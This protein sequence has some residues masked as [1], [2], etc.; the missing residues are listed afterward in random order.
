MASVSR[1]TQTVEVV[2]TKEVPSFTISDL[3]AD[4][5]QVIRNA[6]WSYAEASLWLGMKMA[7]GRTQ[8]EVAA[9]LFDRIPFG[10]LH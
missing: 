1:S 2:T 7:D 9:D 6:L 5:Y 3:T 8:Q 4:E 10:G